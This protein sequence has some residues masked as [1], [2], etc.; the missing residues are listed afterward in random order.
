MC[1]SGRH[2]SITGAATGGSDAIPIPRISALGPTALNTESNSRKPSWYVAR[3]PENHQGCDCVGMDER[4]HLPNIS[5]V[6][7]IGENE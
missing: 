2:V 1:K 4:V 3:F 6:K 7:K 5:R